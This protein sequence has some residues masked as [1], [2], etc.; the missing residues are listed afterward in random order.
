[1]LQTTFYDT[2]GKI[3]SLL[4]SSEEVRLST[5][6]TLQC[7]YIDGLY[8]GDD[9]YIADGQAIAKEPKPSPY[10]IFDYTSKTWILDTFSLDYMKSSCILTV[11]S[12]SSDKITAR[13][14]IYKQ[15]NNIGTSEYDAMRSYIDNIRNLSN[16]ANDSINLATTIEECKDILQTFIQNTEQV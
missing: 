14:P 5:A 1:M 12:L 7:S 8:S 4:E 6:E 9:Y 2:T 3:V 16:I 11:N 10:H 13:Y 15:L